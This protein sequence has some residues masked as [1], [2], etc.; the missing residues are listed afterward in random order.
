MTRHAGDETSGIS[1][2]CSGLNELVRLVSSLHCLSSGNSLTVCH[3][4]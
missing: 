4:C 3:E 1:E 2:T